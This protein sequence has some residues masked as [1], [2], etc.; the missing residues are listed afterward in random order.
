MTGRYL[1]T[2]YF[3]LKFNLSNLKVP[4]QSHYLWVGRGGTTGNLGIEQ[5]IMDHDPFKRID[6]RGVGRLV[7]Y[8]AKKGRKARKGLKVGH[9]P[10]HVSTQV[11]LFLAQWN[12]ASNGDHP[13]FWTAIK[14]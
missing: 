3:R 14:S 12:Q 9:T 7:N 11:Y 2:S 10:T 6:E 5:G 8:A 1:K 4:V 13:R